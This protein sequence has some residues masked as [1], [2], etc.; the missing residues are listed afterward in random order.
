[1]TTYLPQQ[2]AAFPHMAKRDAAIWLRF[3]KTHGDEFI[4]FSYDVAL[5]GLIMPEDTGDEAMRRGYQYSTAVKI[6][7]VGWKGNQVWVIEVRPEAHIGTFGAPIGY[8]LL[9][10]RELLTDLPI[11]PC[12]VCESIQ[13]DVGWLCAQVG[14]QVVRV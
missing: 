1:M 4:G 13:I 5:G 8:A 10:Q 11:V 14:V 7:A 2:V 12:I 6:D 9:F 3:L